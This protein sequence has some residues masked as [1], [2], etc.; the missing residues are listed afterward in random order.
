MFNG[1]RRWRENRRLA[2]LAVP[3]E[4]WEAAVAGWPVAARYQGAERLELREMALRFLLR[5]GFA[6]GAGFAIA[7]EMRL[8]IATMAAV[9]VLKLGLNWY[10]G[11][12]TVVLYEGAFIP[13]HQQPDEFGL[14][15]EHGE[16]L[17][18]E[19]WEQ[20]PVILSWEDVCAAG[21]EEG[22]NVVLHEMAHKLDMRDG[23]VNGAPPLGDLDAV[24]WHAV[25]TEA[26]EDLA[27]R[28]RNGEPL[29]IDGYALEDPG[30]F[31]AVATEVFFEVPERIHAAW[32]ALYQQLSAFYRQDPLAMARRL[33]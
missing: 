17:S 2:A 27:A 11:W 20:G 25:F 8:K 21:T 5:K 4:Q 7:D 15:H 30:E 33:A 32:P 18:G 26:W 29:P 23:S 19:A 31:F 3:P 9:P 28:E 24:R 13:N 6:P 14:V 12:Y 1:L 22:Y 16:V 10:D